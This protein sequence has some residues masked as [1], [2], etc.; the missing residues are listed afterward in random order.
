MVHVGEELIFFN[1]TFKI[2][3]ATKME[4]PHYSPDVFIRVMVV[5]F[6]VTVDA[7]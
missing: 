1:E 6:T 5:N 4:N 7:L 3:F 2:Y